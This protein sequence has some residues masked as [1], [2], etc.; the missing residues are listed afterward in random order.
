V[1]QNLPS[2]ACAEVQQMGNE[3]VLCDYCNIKDECPHGM[4]CYGGEPIEPACCYADLTE[5]ID[6]LAYCEDRGIESELE[7]D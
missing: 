6:Y 4:V 5:L 2:V 7:V 3:E 1:K